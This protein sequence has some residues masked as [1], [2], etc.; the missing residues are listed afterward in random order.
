MISEVIILNMK[1]KTSSNRDAK[2]FWEILKIKTK[3]LFLNKKRIMVETAIN[4]E[5]TKISLDSGTIWII[6]IYRL[7]FYYIKIYC[8]PIDYKKCF[9]NG[10]N[11]DVIRKVF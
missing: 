10:L 7:R 6:I 4:K 3:T 11:T 1:R 9:I 5:N 8:I 2:D